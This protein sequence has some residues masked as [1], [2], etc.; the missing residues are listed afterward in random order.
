LGGGALSAAN[1]S[2]HDPPNASKVK[3]WHRSLNLSIKLTGELLFRSLVC[4]VRGCLGECDP[5]RQRAGAHLSYNAV[6][7]VGQ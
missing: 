1:L 4:R 2:Y 6:R 7:P 3:A 5:A